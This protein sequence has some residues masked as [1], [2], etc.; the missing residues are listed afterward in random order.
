MNENKSLPSNFIITKITVYWCEQM[1]GLE[2]MLP[3]QNLSRHQGSV[4]AL[5][6]HGNFLLSGSEDHEVKV[7]AD[8]QY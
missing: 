3:I 1:W 6:L 8:C 5:T 7:S 4:N 2:Q